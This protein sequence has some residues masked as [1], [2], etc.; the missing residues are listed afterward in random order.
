MAQAWAE[1]FHLVEVK[2]SPIPGI[3]C[4][5]SR[6]SASVVRR[7]GSVTG[8]SYV[9]YLYLGKG[10]VK[11]QRERTENFSRGVPQIGVGTNS[12]QSTH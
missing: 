11:R 7:G 5:I 9:H 2:C 10:L 1:Y 6:G 4:S 3:P 8:V 12:L